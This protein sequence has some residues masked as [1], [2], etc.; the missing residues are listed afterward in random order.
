MA[1]PIRLLLAEAGV[2][3]ED[4][5]YDYGSPPKYEKTD[6]LEDKHQLGLAFPNLPYWIDGKM[7]ISQ[8]L[9][10]LRHLGRKY[11]LIGKTEAEHVRID[12]IEQEIVDLRSAFTSLCH[13]FVYTQLNNNNP[14]FENFKPGYLADLPAKLELIS[15]FLGT[16][17]Y[18]GGDG[19]TYVDFLVYEVLDQHKCL[20]PSC[21]D[22]FP[23][24]KT[25]CA[26][27]EAR[28]RIA[29]YM[30]SDKF[31]RWPVIWPL[32]PPE[33]VICREHFAM[34]L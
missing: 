32:S 4:K 18:F 26:R 5:R 33:F 31:L 30:K 16:Y 7:K 20:E 34:R 23:K 15:R 24:L 28:P 6:W 13:N 19:I 2:A 10:I 8:S 27:I 17:P 21:L 3:Y 14:E 9:A 12:M 25:F 11:G 29:Q 22:T 1:Q